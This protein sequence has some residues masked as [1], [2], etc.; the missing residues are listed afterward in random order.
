MNFF[1]FRQNNS[2]GSFHCDENAGIAIN[3]IIEAN[4]AADANERA[5]KIGLYFNGVSN[6]HDCEC[7]GDRWS[8]QWEGDKGDAVPSIY[9]EAVPY[10]V[11]NENA[12]D[13]IA[14][15]FANGDIHRFGCWHGEGRKAFR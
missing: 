13:S 12:R 6:G 9:G 10:V 1:H 11:P 5:E 2:G 14:I 15:H 4:D 3:V 7:C 8:N